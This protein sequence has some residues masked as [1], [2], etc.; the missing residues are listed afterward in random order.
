MHLV[1]QLHAHV[2]HAPVAA[3]VALARP[4]AVA[5][6]AMRRALLAPAVLAL[7]RAVQC[8]AAC[9]RIAV[10]WAGA[11]AGAAVRTAAA[12]LLVVRER[13][14]RPTHGAGR[15][16]VAASAARNGAAPFVLALVAVARW[17]PAALGPEGAER[18]QEGDEKKETFG[19]AHLS[20]VWRGGGALGGLRPRVL[21]A[22]AKEGNR[23][24]TTDG[25]SYIATAAQ[26]LHV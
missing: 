10:A 5:R 14:A 16:I 2:E 17:V 7:V 20:G 4:R 23:L 22:L 13:V 8:E 6:V 11:G 9:A 18:E 1:V 15:L 24:T 26:G 12:A 21:L 19:A 25:D 3:L